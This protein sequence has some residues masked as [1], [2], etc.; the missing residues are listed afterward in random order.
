MRA[1]DVEREN[2]KISLRVMLTQGGTGFTLFINNESPETIE[3]IR[4]WIIDI[5]NNFHYNYSIPE[6]KKVL[7]PWSE[8][9]LSSFE[10]K[11]FIGLTRRNYYV[12]RLV[13]SRGNIVE[14]PPFIA[15]PGP[16]TE[17][18]WLS[19]GYIEACFN[20]AETPVYDLSD[21]HLKTTPYKGGKAYISFKNIGSVT[22]FLTYESTIVFR[23]IGGLEPKCYAGY[24]VEWY[25]Y[26]WDPKVEKWMLKDSGTIT[27]VKDSKAIYPGEVV[28][29]GFEEPSEIPG[30]GAGI[31]E[32]TYDVFFA[33]SGY[34]EFGKIFFASIYIGTCEIP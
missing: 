11:G 6:E 4:L 28:I 32:G 30:S 16:V 10:L 17:P 8:T 31:R 13:T 33:A 24:L 20:K 23:S 1:Y 3:L 2:E 15:V 19:L 21:S 25:C 26:V 29:L 22:V 7:N 14:T 27:H 9:F 34:D 18:P 5:T 12:M